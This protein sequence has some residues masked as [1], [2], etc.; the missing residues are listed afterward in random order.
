MPLSVTTAVRENPV[1][2]GHFLVTLDVD[3]GLRT[4]TFRMELSEAQSPITDAEL[5]AFVKVAVRYHVQIKGRAFGYLVG[6]I[7]LPDDAPSGGMMA[8]M[9]NTV[10]GWFGGGEPA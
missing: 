8:S 7:V 5:A 6:K 10:R 3:N 2:C 4:H 9:M 1:P